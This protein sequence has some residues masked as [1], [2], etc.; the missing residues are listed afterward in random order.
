M[1]D[2]NERKVVLYT[3]HSAA[4][5]NTTGAD[6]SWHIVAMQALVDNV[7]TQAH[8]HHFV[9]H[10]FKGSDD[11]DQ[12]KV[13]HMVGIFVCWRVIGWMS[14]ELSCKWFSSRAATSATNQK[15]KM[16]LGWVV[17]GGR[18]HAGLQEEMFFRGHCST[19]RPILV[20]QRS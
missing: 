7:T 17:N 3:S 12:S 2:R 9:V 20:L 16:T 5:L 15:K 14:D 19:R 18:R 11:C 6:T 4:S 1:I 13:L 8:V 10:G